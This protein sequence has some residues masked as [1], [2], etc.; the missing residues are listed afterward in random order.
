MHVPLNLN[1]ADCIF[2]FYLINSVSL[3]LSTAILVILGLLTS[4]AREC[5]L[6]RPS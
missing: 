6:P 4:E 3:V 1:P 5:I 2:A